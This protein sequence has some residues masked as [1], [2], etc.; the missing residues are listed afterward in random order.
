MRAR[1]NPS[2]PA[3]PPGGAPLLPRRGTTISI[4]RRTTDVQTPTGRPD[5]VPPVSPGGTPGQSAP[6]EPRPA[7]AELCFAGGRLRGA[8]GQRCFASAEP[9]FAS[10]EP[11]FVDAE[12]HR[13]SA[14]DPRRATPPPPPSAPPS[15]DGYPGH[16]V[17]PTGAP[18]PP[19]GPGRPPRRVL[20]SQVSRGCNARAGRDAC[21]SG[22]KVASRTA[23][24]SGTRRPFPVGP[25]AEC[26]Y[27]AGV[28]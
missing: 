6:S 8:S 4:R 19:P 15:P 21:I 28:R 11:C 12:P 27:R 26:I 14:G 3:G 1:P 2:L 22:E 13:T 16:S 20:P 23:F 5:A 24:G 18:P 17:R 25:G 10:A 7:E 9:C